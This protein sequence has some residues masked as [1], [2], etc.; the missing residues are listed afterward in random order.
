[1]SKPSLLRLWNAFPDHV[2]Y[3]SMKD[4]YT[5][6]GGSAEKNISVPGFGPNGNTCASRLSIAFNDGGAPINA[7]TARAIG[8]K[9]V[10]AAN[11][12]RLI[13]TVA[14]FRAYLRQTLGKPIDDKTS[15]FDD[16]F[17]GK[18]GIIAFSVNWKDATGHIALW[19]GSAYRE[20]SHDD[21]SRYISATDARVK[22]S[23]AEFWE[24][25]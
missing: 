6:Q 4:L 2:K 19:D 21:Y 10:G 11:G 18:K 23:S 8:A 3:P 15:P 12:T 22:T 5:W 13:F 16:A 24:L 1:M 25:S 20:P 7:A 14:S 17:A 9:T